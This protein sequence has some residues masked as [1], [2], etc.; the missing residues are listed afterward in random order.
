[1]RYIIE[2]TVSMVTA[3]RAASGLLLPLVPAMAVFGN[4]LV[5]IAVYRE[6]CLQTVTNLLIVSL[7]ISDFMVAICVMSFGVYYETRTAFL[8]IAFV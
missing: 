1:M 6:K 4:A 3:W 7:A 8:I 2:A 5:I